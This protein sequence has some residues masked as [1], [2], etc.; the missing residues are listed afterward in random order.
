MDSNHLARK[1]REKLAKQSD[2]LSAARDLFLRKGYHE[3]TLEEIARQ[4][5]FGKGTI[6]N[7]FESKEELFR[8]MI[9]QSIGEVGELVQAAVARPGTLEEKLGGYAKALIRYANT[10]IDLFR[11]LAQELGRSESPHYEAT[12]QHLQEK[13]QELNSLVAGYI[14]GE[15][16]RGTVRP[17]DS[18]TLVRLFDG[19][20]RSYCLM[21]GNEKSLSDEELD[22]AVE[23]IV[24]VF[25]H[26]IN[27]KG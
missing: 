13:I 5:D 3:T 9:D 2:I 10:N 8:S 12:L 18:M 24:S 23:G 19:M 16:T 25:F 7:Y 6:Y 15:I 14:A 21:H 17:L 22:S 4:A 1:E 27:S 26:G 11:F 20:V